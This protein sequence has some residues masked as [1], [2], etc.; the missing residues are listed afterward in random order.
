[1]PPDLQAE[2]ATANSLKRQSELAVVGVVI[3]LRIIQQ[4]D[5]QTDVPHA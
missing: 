3:G 4:P 2:S 5:A 1:M